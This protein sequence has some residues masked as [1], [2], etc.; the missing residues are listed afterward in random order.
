M[1]WKIT[2]QTSGFA[3]RTLNRRARAFTLIE[4]LVVIAIIAILAGLLLPALAKA[5]AKAGTTRCLNNLKQLT[6]AWFMYPNDYNDALVK[7][8]VGH[9]MAWINGLPDVGRV[10]YGDRGIT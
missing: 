7:N 8:W 4:L 5:K 6:L 3:D 1:N 2:E 9:P 10:G